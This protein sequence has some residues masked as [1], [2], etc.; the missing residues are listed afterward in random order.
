MIGYIARRSRGFSPAREKLNW[1]MRQI[2]LLFAFAPLHAADGPR[3]YREVVEP[4]FRKQCLGCHGSDKQESG[5][6][7]RSRESAM[8]G[9][10]RGPAIRPGAYLESVLYKL[11]ASKDGPKMPP[12]GDLSTAEI[13]AIGEW[14]D[15]GAPW[16]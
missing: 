3:L 14:I 9:G 12:Q 15:A 7:L 13:E 10:K 4:A 1:S 2:L 8:R 11:L 16:K 6:D 5:L